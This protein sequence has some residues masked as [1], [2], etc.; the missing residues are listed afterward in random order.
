MVLN[1]A[2]D[3]FSKDDHSK[4]LSAYRADYVQMSSSRKQLA[5]EMVDL[6]RLGDEPTLW[7]QDLT[8]SQAAT[9]EQMAETSIFF[10]VDRGVTVL[11]GDATV[12]SPLLSEAGIE[13]EVGTIPE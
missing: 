2:N 7:R 12:V 5:A 13:F 3:G 10:D 11:V 4:A 8:V 1:T 9:V 6:F